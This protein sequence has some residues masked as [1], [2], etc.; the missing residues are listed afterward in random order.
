ME[1]DD[2][3]EWNLYKR[4]YITWKMECRDQELKSFI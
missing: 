3:Y 4:P 2:K 1:I